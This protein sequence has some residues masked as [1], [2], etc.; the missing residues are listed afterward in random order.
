[1]DSKTDDDTGTLR[2]LAIEIEIRKLSYQGNLSPSR[3]VTWREEC[4]NNQLM[5]EEQEL[6]YQISLV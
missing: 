1:M 5:R 3:V 2:N 6:E 4:R